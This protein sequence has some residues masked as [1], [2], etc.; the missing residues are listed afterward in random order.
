MKC[1]HSNEKFG[2]VGSLVVRYLWCGKYQK[3]PEPQDCVDCS[4]RIKNGIQI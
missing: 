1:P 3:Y 2:D 4:T